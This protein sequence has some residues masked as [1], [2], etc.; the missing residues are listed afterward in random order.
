MGYEENEKKTI[1]DNDGFII[2][3][4]SLKDS[5]NNQIK[6]K[7]C[8]LKLPHPF[9]NIY[10]TKVCLFLKDQTEV[11]KEF[12]HIKIL[13]LNKLRTKYES[14]ESKRSLCASY[15]IF[16]ADDRILP[17]LT[18]LI[19]RFFFLKKKQPIPVKILTKK[20]WNLQLLRA[21]CGTYAFSNI[22]TCLNI[23]VGRFNQSLRKVTENLI[24]IVE[25]INRLTHINWPSIKGLYVR[26]KQSVALSIYIK[27]K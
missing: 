27:F 21:L 1:D 8:H 6:A 10:R 25:Q 20:K 14:F 11:K 22:G 19:G 5:P 3:V 4:V 9:N 16:L 7:P 12:K 24:S 26:T 2:L 18:K 15:D 23:K 17:L 13:E